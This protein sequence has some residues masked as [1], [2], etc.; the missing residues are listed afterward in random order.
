MPEYISGKPEIQEDGTKVTNLIMTMFVG[1]GKTENGEKFELLTLLNQA[2]VVR[3][4]DGSQVAWSWKELVE[5]AFEIH[6]EH[7]KA[8]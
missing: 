4:E 5:K 8:D 1:E 3:F 6:N 7:K 2:P